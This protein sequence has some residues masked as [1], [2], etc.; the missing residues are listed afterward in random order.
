MALSALPAAADDLVIQIGGK[1][2]QLH[3]VVHKH[4]LQLSGPAQVWNT[5]R[6]RRSDRTKP[7]PIAAAMAL[8][9]RQEGQLVG[10]H[11]E[12]VEAGKPAEL[13]GHAAQQ[14]VVGGQVLQGDAAVQAIWQGH[15]LVHGHIQRLQLLQIADLCR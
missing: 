3:V 2:F 9:E 13:A 8:T 11:G 7:E 6:I 10:R 4:K 5:Q 12:L 15:Q 14:V 1:A